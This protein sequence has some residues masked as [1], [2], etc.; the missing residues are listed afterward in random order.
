MSIKGA[1]DGARC[2]VTAV[3][4]NDAQYRNF[5]TLRDPIQRTGFSEAQHP[6]IIGNDYDNFF[7]MNDL[8]RLI[9]EFHE[10]EG[11]VHNINCM[12]VKHPVNQSLCFGL[13]HIRAIHYD[14]PDTNNN[15]Q[16]NAAEAELNRLTRFNDAQRAAFADNIP[17]DTAVEYKMEI[18]ELLPLVQEFMN[19]FSVQKRRS[20][21]VYAYT[22]YQLFRRWVMSKSRVASQ[23]SDHILSQCFKRYCQIHSDILQEGKH[24]LP[25]YPQRYYVIRPVNFLEIIKD[26]CE[27]QEDSSHIYTNLEG[28]NT[29]F[30]KYL[31]YAETN[32]IAVLP[33]LDSNPPDKYPYILKLFALASKNNICAPYLEYEP[34]N[35]LFKVYNRPVR[36]TKYLF[37]LHFLH[38]LLFFLFCLAE[39]MC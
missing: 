4:I 5:L 30:R 37:L 15:A 25:G 34:S 14:L 24:Q 29:L 3:D 32:Q 20:D 35:R 7:E 22:L 27:S 13:P 18:P 6:V 28:L 31:S 11:S 23:Q 33:Q 21:I 9:R 8:I 36:H 38:F 17:Y 12:R 26:F 2:P 19:E 39:A 1:E 16:Y 10:R